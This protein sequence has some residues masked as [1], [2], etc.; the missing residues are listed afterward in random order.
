MARL[1]RRVPPSPPT[2]IY[3]AT[4]R[5]APSARV[6]DGDGSF[7]DTPL[8]NCSVKGF[9][10]AYG[11]P[12]SHSLVPALYHPPYLGSLSLSLSF[13]VSFFV[14]FFIA[15]GCLSLCWSTKT[16]EVET[17]VDDHMA[18]VSEDAW[19]PGRGDLESFQSL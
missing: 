10:W 2:A 12:T 11:P 14:S 7:T 1:C 3:P 13:F 9:P 19:D 4:L 5:P 6:P 17:G 18:C 8:H 16:V 15:H